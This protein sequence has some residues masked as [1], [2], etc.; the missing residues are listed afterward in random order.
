MLAYSTK[1]INLQKK[2]KIISS[3]IFKKF[4]FASIINLRAYKP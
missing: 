1:F 3:A 4:N 2:K